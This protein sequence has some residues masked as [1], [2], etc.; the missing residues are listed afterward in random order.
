MK[1][2]VTA[3]IV[4]SLIF[5]AALLNTFYISNKVDEMLL[6]CDGMTNDSSAYETDTLVARWQSCKTIISLSV[7]KTVL[8]RAENA[9]LA[10]ERYADSPKDFKYQLKMLKIALNEIADGQ[11]F[12]VESIF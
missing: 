6:I 9:I 7:H 1:S 10:L 12:T 3:A 4:L 8:E 2:F 11:K 5:A